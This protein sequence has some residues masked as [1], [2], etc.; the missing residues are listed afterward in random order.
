MHTPVAEKALVRCP[1]RMGEPLEETPH[2]TPGPTPTTTYGVR[3]GDGQEGTGDPG[4]RPWEL[5]VLLGILVL[6]AWLRLRELNL[7]EFKLDEAFAVDL[8]RR[9]L[10][11]DL[12]TVGLP[13]SVG[14]R[15]PPLFIYM[16]AIPLAL[17]DDPL[18]TTAFVGI[19]AV[20]A[21]GLTYV[22]L[23]PRFGA[24]AALGS[25]ALFA[26]APWA[27]LF[28][29]KTWAQDLLPIFTV[30]LLWCMFLVLERPRSRAVLLVPVLL[31]LVFQLNFSALALAVPCAILLLYRAREIHVLALVTGVGVAVLLLAPWLGHEATHGFEDARRV[32]GVGK[33][34]AGSFPGTGTAYA[35]WRTLR[36]TGATGWD[37]VSGSSIGLVRS[38]MGAGWTLGMLAS[39]ASGLLLL[40][41]VGSLA[42][43]L[44]LTGRGK[45][46]WPFVAMPLRTGRRALLLVWLVGICV[47]YPTAPTSQVHLHYLIVTYPV[48]FAVQGVLL[49]DL[50]LLMRGRARRVASAAAAVVV[51]FVAAGF[52]AFSVGFH[53]FLDGNGGTAG[54]YGVVYRD[55]AAL[56]RVAREQSLRIADAPVLDFLVT[57][58]MQSPRG[59]PPLV[60]VR[61]RLKKNSR[62]LPCDGALRSFGAL[63][64]CLPAGNP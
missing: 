14:A 1:H 53:D 20:I 55:K 32:F 45:R 39:L 44:A 58:D 59:T 13:S 22:V 35:A 62:P 37:Y 31:C 48:S 27:V 61:N 42:V 6:G 8:A 5:V 38:E 2:D 26:T 19:L 18:A 16:T 43:Q 49:A 34:G 51:V 63:E 41:G 10:D 57:G 15:N 52:V 40:V 9:V 17:R 12:T 46:T 50:A 24:L 30:L 33:G 25:A 4:R 21:I 47:T 54:D 7:V 3:T 60:I 11:G 28:G 64:A 56:A 23:R 36:V 29:R